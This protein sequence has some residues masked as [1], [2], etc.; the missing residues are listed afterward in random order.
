MTAWLRERLAKS[1]AALRKP[2]EE[3][4]DGFAQ[5]MAEAVR[6]I[7]A[8]CDVRGACAGF[9]ERLRKLRH[10]TPPGDRLKT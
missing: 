5:R 6:G 4:P 7:N 1:A 10:V 2:W 9:P 3:T 8:T